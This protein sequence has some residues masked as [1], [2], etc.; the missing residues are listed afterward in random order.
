MA[1]FGS[2]ARAQV[3]KHETR[4]FDEQSLWRFIWEESGQKRTKERKDRGVALNKLDVD[5]AM[6]ELGE[7]LLKSGKDSS[8][9]YVANARRKVIDKL[10][11]KAFREEVRRGWL[12]RRLRRL[13]RLSASSLE[14]WVAQPVEH[15][16]ILIN[17]LQARSLLRVWKYVCNLERQ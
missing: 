16:A 12:G 7:D 15:Y 13:A 14:G 5:R 4:T 9:S 2:P 3:S 10:T 11:T 1:R 6:Y 8:A 17:W